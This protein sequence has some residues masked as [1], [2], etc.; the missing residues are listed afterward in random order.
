MPGEPPALKEIFCA[1]DRA[2]AL[3]MA[4]PYLLGKYRDYAKWGQD[5]AIPNN[6]SFNKELDELIQ[7]RFILGSIEDCYKE[8]KP[9]WEKMGINQF[10]YRT[11]W[12]GM[13]LSTTLQSM[14]LISNELLPELRKV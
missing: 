9:Y 8:L 7:G 11:Q 6:E 1:K 5:N 3:K 4:I 10:I 14:R 13:P 12:A 2:T